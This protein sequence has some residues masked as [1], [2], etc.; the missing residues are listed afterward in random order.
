MISVAIAMPVAAMMAAPVVVASV[1]IASAVVAVMLSAVVSSSVFNPHFLSH[2][3]VVPR[4][5]S[6]VAISISVTAGFVV[7][8]YP[9][10]DRYPLVVAVVAMTVVVANMHICV[11]VAVGYGAA[12]DDT[13][14]NAS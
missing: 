2:I 13:T 5:P 11:N 9:R 1:M 4:Y 8:W 14:D 12:E 6:F 7:S 10:L 3:A